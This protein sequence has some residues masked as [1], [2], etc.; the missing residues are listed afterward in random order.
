M[1]TA[2]VG[3]AFEHHPRSELYSAHQASWDWPIERQP[4]DRRP[5]DEKHIRN[6]PIAQNIVPESHFVIAE[7][8]E[9]LAI[10]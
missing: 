9:C 8:T 1:P 7:I 4:V 3:V 6:R 5:I 10:N 2:R